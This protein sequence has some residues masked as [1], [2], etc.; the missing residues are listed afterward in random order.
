[1]LGME[2]F[3]QLLLSV[4]REV[5]RHIAIDEAIS[6]IAPWLVA[7]L[8]VELL[9]V[10]RLDLKRSTLDTVAIGQCC[11]AALPSRTRSDCAA[12][13]MERLL[14]WCLAGRVMH[15]ALRQCRAT[16][17]EAVPDGV[18]GDGLIGPLVSDEGPLGLAIATF[19]G[20]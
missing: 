1:M 16:L 12:R 14:D 18:E 11:S 9:L 10:R 15:G 19:A 3:A 7:E 5:C 8:P 4:W 13:D 6:R 20:N 2:R 17:P